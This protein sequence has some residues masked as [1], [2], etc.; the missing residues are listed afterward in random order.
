M[1]PS[2]LRINKTLFKTFGRGTT[3]HSPA[4]SMFVYKKDNQSDS[5]FSFS[6]SKKVSKLAVKRNKLRRQGY[7]VI[8]K[9]L[10]NIK[11]GYFIVFNF[12]KEAISLSYS[13][14]ESDINILL[15]KAGVSV[16]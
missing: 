10:E 3:F 16:G 6:V 11:K 13:Q 12:K 4:I 5:Q 7:S 8:G 1:L 2:K 15:H 9:N 14:I